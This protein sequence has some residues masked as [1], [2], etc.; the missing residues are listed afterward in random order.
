MDR[1]S[2]GRERKPPQKKREIRVA[3]NRGRTCSGAGVEEE[4]VIGGG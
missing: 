2:E 1:W 4:L 3:R